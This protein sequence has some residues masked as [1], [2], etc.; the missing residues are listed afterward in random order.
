MN[1]FLPATSKAVSK[2][3]ERIDQLFYAYADKSSGMIE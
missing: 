3:M 2:E 1:S